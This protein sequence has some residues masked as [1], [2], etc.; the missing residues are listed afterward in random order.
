MSSCPVGR[1]RIIKKRKEESFLLVWTVLDTLPYMK[2]IHLPLPLCLSVLWLPSQIAHDSEYLISYMVPGWQAIAEWIDAAV[3]GTLTHNRAWSSTISLDRRKIRNVS[4]MS[5]LYDSN[6]KW[7]L[8][9]DCSLFR[10]LSFKGDWN[11]YKQLHI[12]ILPTPYF[13]LA[14][15][16]GKRLFLYPAD[17]IAPP[18]W[19]TLKAL[20]VL[21]PTTL[22]RGLEKDA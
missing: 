7:Q 14:V 10:K 17:A 11:V 6:Q 1:K 21:K 5:L 12:G 18:L 9:A 20:A 8:H 22:V 2:Q 19:L 4:K 16:T 15:I 3:P 13:D